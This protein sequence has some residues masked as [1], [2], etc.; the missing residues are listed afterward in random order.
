MILDG[1]RIV[2]DCEGDVLAG[3]AD[4]ANGIGIGFWH[5]KG[6]RWKAVDGEGGDEWGS[7]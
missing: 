6:A 7:Q 4:P 5:H 2:R 1:L 3:A